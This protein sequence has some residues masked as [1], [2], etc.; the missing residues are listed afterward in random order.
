M[1]R[2]PSVWKKQRMLMLIRSLLEA[3]STITGTEAMK[4]PNK[5]GILAPMRI[6][7]DVNLQQGQELR[8][9]VGD[10]ETDPKA[11]QPSLLTLSST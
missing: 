4:H 7:A 9:A 5:K 8:E 10:V 1:I 2:L 6:I 11:K 3:I